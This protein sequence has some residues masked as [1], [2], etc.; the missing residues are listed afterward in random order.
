MRPLL[1]AALVT[2]VMIGRAR[3]DEP[4]LYPGLT[5]AER[6]LFDQ[7]RIR[8][9]TRETVATGLGPVF[10]ADSCVACHRDPAPGG[11]SATFV[12][13]FGR[14]QHS[15]EFD[16]MTE[17]GGPVLQAN[18]ITVDGCSVAGEVIP[19]EATI[20]TRRKT[21]PLF[22]LGLVDTIPDRE[23]LRLADPDDANH[24][25]IAG[26]VNFVGSRVGRFGWKAQIVTL[27]QFA[28][29]AYANE[30]GITSPDLPNELNPQGG[31]VVCDT[32]PDPEDDGTRIDAVTRF[33]LLLAPL[34]RPHATAAARAGRVVFRRIGC[35][36]CH[37]KRLRA[38][39]THPV[40]AVRGKRVP[41][42]SDLLLHDLGPALGDGMPQG[43]AGPNDFRTAPLWGVRASAPYLH[44]GRAATLEEAIL[45]HA[46]E[47][48]AAR[49]RFT[50]LSPTARAAL[51]AFLDTL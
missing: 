17:F 27:R 18:G 10:N 46:G 16:P 35:E 39:P 20:R 24:D 25:G 9:Q 30:I 47:A 40:A 23:I 14:T 11:A 37:T 33:V 50:D 43:F 19:P 22:G 26:R 51:I 45:A 38:G 15:G 44:D 13:R 28:A 36:A 2:L 21:P 4:P 42:Y 5:P 41:L 29:N 3:S 1:I 8:F 6:I 49:V 7:G 34:P 31:P 32:V 48:D 12:V